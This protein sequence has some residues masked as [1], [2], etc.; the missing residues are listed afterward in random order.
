MAHAVL[1]IAIVANSKQLLLVL[2]NDEVTQSRGASLH[3]HRLCWFL[4]APAAAPSP[5]LTFSSISAISVSVTRV[6]SS[7][8]TCNTGFCRYFEALLLLEYRL[9]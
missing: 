5:Q 2:A 1:N 9:G 8:C 7:C 6:F 3:D 4:Q